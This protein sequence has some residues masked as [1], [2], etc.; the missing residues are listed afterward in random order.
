MAKS[1]K[2]EFDSGIPWYTDMTVTV[3]VHFPT[4][5]ISCNYCQFCRNEDRYQRFS[6]RLTRE[7]LVFPFDD[8]GRECPLKL[9][10]ENNEN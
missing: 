6:C 5:H 9:K 1:K 2:A 8:V 4:D 10:E 7:W 3:T